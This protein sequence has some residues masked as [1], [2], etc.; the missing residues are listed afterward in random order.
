MSLEQ[1]TF[2]PNFSAWQKAARAAL[3]RQVAPEQIVWE[4][5]AGEQPPLGLFAENEDAPPPSSPDRQYFVPKRFV[6]L[7][8]LT[9]LHSD[10]QRWALLY[11]LLWRLTNDESKLLEIVVDPDTARAL[12]MEKSVRHD[13]HKM[14][15]FVRFREVDMFGDKWFVAWF[16]PEHHIVEHNSKFFVDRFSSMNWSIL[17]PDLCVHW[18]RSE[19]RFTAGVDK[20]H[21]PVNDR[22]ENLWLTY[23]KSIF[24]PARVKVHAMQAEMPK[25]YWKNLPETAAIPVLLREAPEEVD[26]MMKRSAAKQSGRE[27][28]EWR[29]APV[30]DTTSLKTL[31]KAACGCTACP[32]YRNATQ[33]VFGEGPVMP[34]SC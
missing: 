7:A 20:S 29:P 6:D 30:P 22:V 19:V 18:D 9:A 12:A 26:I 15:A 31:E 1:I 11:R 27:G 25:K 10:P 34:Q 5:L 33:T 2:A 4:E 32:L 23:Y 21:A 16:E 8:R 24:N 13:I 17:T 28:D 14:R 3:Y